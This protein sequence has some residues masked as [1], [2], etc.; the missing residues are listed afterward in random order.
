M[1]KPYSS[2][3][4]LILPVCSTVITGLRLAAMQEQSGWRLGR[5]CGRPA[6]QPAALRRPEAATHRH[7]ARPA[8]I[9]HI[10]HLRLVKWGDA[11]TPSDPGPETVIIRDGHG[12]TVARITGPRVGVKWVGDLTGDGIPAVV[13][14]VWG[15]A[16]HAGYLYYVYSAGPQPRC[17]LAYD[18]ENAM[19]DSDPWPEFEVKD[20]DGDGR[21]R[22]SPLTTDSPTGMRSRGGR[23]AML[24]ALECPSCSGSGGGALWTSR[25][26]TARGSDRDWPKPSRD[27]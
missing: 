11:R 2:V 5:P 22:S 15:G 27:F 18:K 1:R 14:E 20:L 13:L 7:P 3:W 4:W 26:S 17:L 16:T 25:A 8:W 9:K 21:R 19:E 6:G 23:R 24:A 12:R 10:G